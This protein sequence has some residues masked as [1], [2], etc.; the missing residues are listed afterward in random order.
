MLT[1][2]HTFLH[3]GREACKC[4]PVEGSAFE[5]H[6]LPRNAQVLKLKR[7]KREPSEFSW[8]YFYS[9]SAIPCEKLRQN[10]SPLQVLMHSEVSEQ[11]REASGQSEMLAGHPPHLLSIRAHISVGSRFRLPNCCQGAMSPQRLC[12]NHERDAR[13]RSI[14]SLCKIQNHTSECGSPRPSRGASRL[15]PPGQGG[16][17]RGFF[18][19]TQQ[20]KLLLA[21]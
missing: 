4:L 1:L 20:Y 3:A 14:L 21:P 15:N 8:V 19:K 11:L 5:Q 9:Y 2:P 7:G 13:L 12:W 10:Q 6:T 18:G 17:S 16:G